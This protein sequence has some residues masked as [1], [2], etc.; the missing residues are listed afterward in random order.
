LNHS[1]ISAFLGVAGWDG[2]TLEPLA[3]DASTRRYFRVRR[4]GEC[5]VL[6]DASRARESVAPFLCIGSHLR[7]LG[8]STPEVLFSEAPAGLLLLEDFGDRNFA[9]L[10]DGASPALDAEALFALAV[11][12]L[13]ALH[14]CPQ[15]APDGWRVYAPEIML[16]DLDLFLE[17][18]TPH[19]SDATAAAWRDAWRAVLPLAH[20]V[21]Q[22]LLLRDYHVANLMFLPE[23]EG[24]RCAGLLDFQD[25]YRGPV[26]YDLVS[27]LEDARRD[28]PDALRA[29]LLERYGAQFP[30]LDRKS[31]E[32]SLAVVAALRHTRVL[33]IFERLAQHE[34][35]PEYRRCHTA[36]LTRLL[37]QAL[38]HPAL[39]P[40]QHWMQRHAV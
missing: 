36:R 33:A 20:A 39:E 27:L 3:G 1:D 25:A 15:A 6:M 34:G 31:F 21:P 37:D 28:V 5:A 18:R 16:A 12:V 24:V 17:W 35:R 14:Q 11:D 26:T 38:R 8:F 22:S 13:A 23:R 29:R 40:V 32:T 19:V 7:E 30:G 10:M 2:A 9:R 4:A